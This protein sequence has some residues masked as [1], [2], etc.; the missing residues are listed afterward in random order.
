MVK[1]ILGGK[2]GLVVMGGD[3]RPRGCGF[4]YRGHVLDGHSSHML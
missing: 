1:Y 4:E 2:P 3:S